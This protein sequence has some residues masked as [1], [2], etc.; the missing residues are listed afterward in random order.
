MTKQ[1]L[2]GI[3]NDQGYILPLIDYGSS[4]WGTTSKANIVRISEL[5]K[6]AAQT[7]LNV[8]FD[9]AFAEMF[10]T[11]GWHTVTQRRNYNKAVLIYKM[12]IDLTKSYISYLVTP[13]AQL[14][15]RTLRSMTHAL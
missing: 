1:K 9:T 14:H 4:T 10:N 15:N 11:L 13:V 7:M 2:L 5:Q 6:T 12:L 8:P 3:Y